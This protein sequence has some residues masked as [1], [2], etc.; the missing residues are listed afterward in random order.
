MAYKTKNRRSTISMNSEHNAA[1]KMGKPAAFVA[2]VL[3][4]P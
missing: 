1:L 3:E 2:L 4:K